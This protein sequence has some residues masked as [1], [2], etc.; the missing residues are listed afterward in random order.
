[1]DPMDDTA[2][3]AGVVAE[4]LQRALGQHGIHVH[5]VEGDEDGVHA[6]F[7]DLRHAETMLALA[8]E[9]A[10][11][12]GSLYDRVSTGCV[13]M[14]DL[15]EADEA[16]IAHVL[17]TS[18]TWMVH[19]AMSGRFVGWHVSVTMPSADANTVTARLNELKRGYPV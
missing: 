11:G 2:Y 7:A 8:V 4:E 18:W 17:D 16:V 1:M 5:D 12:P 15:P 9:G 3:W 10:D 19:P 13:T 6:S 14:A